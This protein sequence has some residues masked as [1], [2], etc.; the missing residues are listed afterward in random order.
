[1]KH[2]SLIIIVL[3]GMSQAAAQDDLTLPY[4]SEGVRFVNEKVI[5]ENGDTHNTITTTRWPQVSTTT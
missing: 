2:L 5:V 1:M 4:L 3:M